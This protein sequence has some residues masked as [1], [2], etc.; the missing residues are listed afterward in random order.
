MQEKRIGGTSLPIDHPSISL[1]KMSS[2]Q[3]L[4]KVLGLSINNRKH[5]F[6]DTTVFERGSS[7]VLPLPIN[8]RS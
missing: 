4:S 8:Y 2:T 5:I 6:I 3:A 1:S 7:R